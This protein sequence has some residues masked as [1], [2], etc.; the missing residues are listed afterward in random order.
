MR[1]GL[2][3]VTAIAGL[4]AG[5]WLCLGIGSALAAPATTEAALADRVL[6][7]PNAPVTSTSRPSRS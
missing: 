1:H 3:C 6:G 2:R 4:L 7:D 5:L